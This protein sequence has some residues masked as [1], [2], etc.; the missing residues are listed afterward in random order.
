MGKGLGNF[1][2]EGLGSLGLRA[3]PLPHS[4]QVLVEGFSRCMSLL[5]SSKSNGCSRSLEM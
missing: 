1:G 4:G 3:D 5:G 2:V